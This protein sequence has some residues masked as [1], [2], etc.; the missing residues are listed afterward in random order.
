VFEETVTVPI[1]AV[2]LL[3]PLLV[4]GGA[5][6][7]RFV[8]DASPIQQ[9]HDRILRETLA[10]QESR[11]TQLKTQVDSLEV[12]VTRLREDLHWEREQNRRLRREI[13]FLRL[14]DETGAAASAKADIVA[15]Q[16]KDCLETE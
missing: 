15:S 7:W 2:A 11:V 3:V 14:G 9:N 4:A 1:W 16:L 12:Q 8:H 10:A 13:S 5:Y 6:F